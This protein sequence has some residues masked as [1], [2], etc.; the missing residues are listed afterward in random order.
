MGSRCCFLPEGLSVPCWCQ[1]VRKPGC[2]DSAGLY[3]SSAIPFGSGRSARVRS[4]ELWPRSLYPGA[5]PANLLTSGT[6]GR[7]RCRAYESFFIQSTIPQLGSMRACIVATASSAEGVEVVQT[8]FPRAVH[9]FASLLM[10]NPRL[11]ARF[12]A[13]PFDLARRR[14]TADPKAIASRISSFGYS[15]A[16]D[17]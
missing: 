16:A 12:F 1:R 2:L 5:V 14:V 15:G 6:R 4:Q 9:G 17:F 8:A 7:S 3:V 11:S 10:D 13:Q